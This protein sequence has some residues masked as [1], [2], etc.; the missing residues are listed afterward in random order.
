MKIGLDTKKLQKNDNQSTKN[1]KNSQKT[2]LNKLKIF[3]KDTKNIQDEFEND[4]YE[5]PTSELQQKFPNDIDISLL[6]PE[7]ITEEGFSKLQNNQEEITDIPFL[8]KSETEEFFIEPEILFSDEKMETLTESTEI[9]FPSGI[10]DEHLVE[11]GIEIPQE[12]DAPIILDDIIEQIPEIT[13]DDDD[14]EKD[15]IHKQIEDEIITDTK[16]SD[17]SPYKIANTQHDNFLTDCEFEALMEIFS[18]LSKEEVDALP[19]NYKK[20]FYQN[21]EENEAFLDEETD[22]I[23]R[24]K[25]GVRSTSYNENKNSNEQNI[26]DFINKEIQVDKIS[27]PVELLNKTLQNHHEILLEQKTL[28]MIK[29]KLNCHAEV[30]ELQEDI[31]RMQEK[32]D[33]KSAIVIYYTNMSVPEAELIKEG[34]IGL[35][36]YKVYVNNE[37]KKC[38][39]NF[40][41]EI[42]ANTSVKIETGI[43]FV[44]DA[45]CHAEVYAGNDM[46]DFILEKNYE[47]KGNMILE[48][49]ALTDTFISKSSI[50][51]CIQIS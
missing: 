8:Q 22:K 48:Y 26:Q 11:P 51:G 30:M 15:N 38:N 4:T 36:A 2:K 34:V 25:L 44:T 7:H 28:E 37:M 14:D 46:N 47:E 39:R 40:E 24:K 32:E 6:E 41:I 42:K 23:I 10:E 33:N 43:S 31:T 3:G 5:F 13:L 49:T 21:F 16:A 17:I 27:L 9:F 1:V 29:N 20:I 18:G 12:L 35:K 19:Q 45:N 50:V